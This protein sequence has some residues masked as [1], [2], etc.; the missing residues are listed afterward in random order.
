VIFERAAML[1][2]RRSSPETFRRAAIGFQFRHL[3]ILRIR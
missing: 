3:K 2:T 1:V